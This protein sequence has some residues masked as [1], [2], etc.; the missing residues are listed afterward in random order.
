MSIFGGDNELG[1][2]LQD[3]VK[4]KSAQMGQ[5][6]KTYETWPYFV[7]HTLFHGEKEHFK[8]WRHLPFAE[9]MVKSE[10][11][12]DAG[13]KLFKEKNYSD[14]V[15]RY[16]E[17]GTLI[18]YCYSTDPGW[19]KNNRGIDDDVLV[20]V[21][22]TG[23]TPEDKEQQKRFRTALC[24]NIAACKLKLSNWEEAIVACDT[25]LELDPKN[26]KALFRRAIARI[27]PGKCTAYDQ[28]LAI[29]D[30]VKA[31]HLDPDDSMV[32]TKLRELRQARKEQLAKD[33]TTFNNMFDR[34]TIYKG[35]EGGDGTRPSAA[36]EEMQAIRA[37]INGI[38][39]DDSLEKRTADAELLR[40]LYMRNGKEEEA[41][42]LN[43]K[44]QAAKKAIKEREAPKL[45]WE[46]PTEDMIEDAKRFSLDLTDPLVIQELKRMEKEGYDSLP[47]EEAPPNEGASESDAAFT[48]DV[49]SGPSVPWMRY[50]YLFLA[51]AV[52]WR[53]L[54][55]GILRWILVFLWRLL[56]GPLLS[57][58]GVPGAFNAAPEEEHGGPFSAAYNTIA[59]Q[60]GDGDGEE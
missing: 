13:N 9:K 8:A 12:K 57:L 23:E 51:M 38:S 11:L 16:E 17:A 41:K 46:N 21:E 6:R 5:K 50:V 19:R 53:L 35:D 59:G 45:D 1:N 24:V 31:S 49:P 7:Q 20:L 54:D 56:L 47:P 10:E 33:K 55:A 34:G 32:A 42:E 48:S 26:V 52:A 37:R 18:H 22:D 3:A 40:D 58:L 36:H 44:I 2:M 14:A 25:A 60:F 15:D 39:E 29:K 28:D 27:T 30:L 43:E 4:L